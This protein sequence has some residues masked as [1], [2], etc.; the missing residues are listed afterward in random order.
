MTSM[1]SLM[2][3]CAGIRYSPAL[4]PVPGRG[5]PD[6]GDEQPALPRSLALQASAISSDAGTRPDRRCCARSGRGR[7][8]CRTA[9]LPRTT[10]RRS[11]TMATRTMVSTKLRNHHQRVADGAGAWRRRRDRLR[12]ARLR[13]GFSERRG[14][15]TTPA[16]P[17]GCRAL[18][19]RRRRARRPIGS[20]CQ[21][22]LR[23]GL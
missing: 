5:K 22:P 7:R 3:A 13:S 12:A 10:R 4:R 16:A 6:A 9:S 20:P 19:S 1:M 14:L 11:A 15:A 2:L 17:K 21:T 23:R 8:A 18:S